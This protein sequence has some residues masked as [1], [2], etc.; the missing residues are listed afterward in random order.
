MKKIRALIMMMLIL[1]FSRHTATAEEKGFV[2]CYDPYPPF[3]VGEFDKYTREG[4]KVQ[5]LEELGQAINLKFKV[6]LLP[7]TRCLQET[8]KGTLD[9]V[10][11][12][13]KTSLREKTLVFTRPAF[14]QETVLF[15]RKKSFPNGLEWKNWS[16][17]SHLKLGTLL[18]T[19]ID[20]NM[21][22]N[23][24]IK[25]NLHHANDLSSL[26]TQLNEKRID[27]VAIERSVGE[28]T[29]QKSNFSLSIASSR[30]SISEQES[31]Y[32]ISKKSPLL[33]K[34]DLINGA[35]DAR[36][37]KAFGPA[38]PSPLLQSPGSL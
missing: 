16:E 25:N 14:V 37:K 12:I 8:A 7:L 35:I 9:G 36:L 21:E 13:Y 20:K 2:F 18:G 38:I 32:A 26:F 30:Q 5:A 33:E 27:L 31:F 11:P 1:V 3:A 15:Y 22:E 4:L 23:F 29:I 24:Q 34:L 19:Y 28:W 17:L 10:L 6:I